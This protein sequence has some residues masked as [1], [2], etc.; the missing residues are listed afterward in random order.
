GPLGTGIAIAPRDV[1]GE[2][3]M[4]KITRSADGGSE[5]LVK[6]EGKLLE[7]WVAELARICTQPMAGSTCIQLDLSAVTFVDES[8]LR[9][10]RKLLDRGVGIAAVSGFVAELLRLEKR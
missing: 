10:L 4:L 3:A 5:L 8:G 1:F 9:L 6:L 2:G 7:P